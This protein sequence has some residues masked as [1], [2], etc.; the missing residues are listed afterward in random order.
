MDVDGGEVAD[1]PCIEQSFDQFARLPLP[2]LRSTHASTR[3]KRDLKH[4]HY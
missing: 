3:Y 4:A 1:Q 2:P